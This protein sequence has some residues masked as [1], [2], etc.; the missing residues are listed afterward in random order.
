MQ[1]T[2]QPNCPTKSI[3]YQKNNLNF[4]SSLGARESELTIARKMLQYLKLDLKID[5][6]KDLLI[7][8]FVK[9]ALL[10]DGA[11][12]AFGMTAREDVPNGIILTGKDKNLLGYI[13]K[14]LAD[15]SDTDLFEVDGGDLAGR[16]FLRTLDDIADSN[17]S[18]EFYAHPSGIVFLYPPRKRKILQVFNLGKINE[19]NTDL[20]GLN[21]WIKRYFKPNKFTMVLS[22]DN[23]ESV[24]QELV[25]SPNFPIKIDFND[26]AGKE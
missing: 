19:N 8:T 3:S 25:T 15:K 1:L 21:A 23:L 10:E 14:W 13:Q 26:A 12:Q 6:A 7:D 17:V 18:Q 22:S 20:Q 5:K 24:P 9:P 11:Y 2:I 16:K 4:K